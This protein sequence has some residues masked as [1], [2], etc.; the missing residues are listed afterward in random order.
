MFRI[1]PDAVVMKMGGERGN[2]PMGE[3]VEQTRAT[4]PARILART[5]DFLMRCDLMN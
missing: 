4:L 5:L 2:M 1:H 3:P